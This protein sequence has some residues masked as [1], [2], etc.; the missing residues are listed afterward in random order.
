MRERQKR[1]HLCYLPPLAVQENRKV[2]VQDSKTESAAYLLLTSGYP[3]PNG[4]IFNVVRNLRCPG[5]E[6]AVIKV[7]VRMLCIDVSPS[8]YFSGAI[9]LFFRGYASGAVA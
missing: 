2:T 4:S 8:Q 1:L 7:L 3:S 5:L 6:N 9:R